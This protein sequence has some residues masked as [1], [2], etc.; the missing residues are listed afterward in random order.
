MPFDATLCAKL[1]VS[2]WLP[3]FKKKPVASLAVSFLN[4]GQWYRLLS[5]LRQQ[6]APE[7]HFCLVVLH[8]THSA[9]HS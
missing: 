3:L 5:R 9:V 4:M 8:I 7:L 2:D 6:T 1:T